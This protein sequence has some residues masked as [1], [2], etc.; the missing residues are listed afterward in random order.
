[1][2]TKSYSAM[3]SKTELYKAFLNE[4]QDK[5]TREEIFEE[6]I[7][8]SVEVV[9]CYYGRKE[10]LKDDQNDEGAMEP[11]ESPTT[12]FGRNNHIKSVSKIAYGMLVTNKE[13]KS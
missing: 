4:M 6:S 13:E 7:L 10:D 11:L 3:T 12:T 2:A 8:L 1:M 5:Q 9:F